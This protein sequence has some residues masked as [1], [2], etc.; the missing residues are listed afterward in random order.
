MSR[1]NKQASEFVSH[2]K[3]SKELP[4][5]HFSRALVFGLLQPKSYKRQCLGLVVDHEVVCKTKGVWQ[6]ITSVAVYLHKY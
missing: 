2:S 4:I 6:S 3:V 1:G 5:H